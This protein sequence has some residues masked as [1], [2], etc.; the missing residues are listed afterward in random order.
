MAT[1]KLKVFANTANTVSTTAITNVAIKTTSSSEQAVIKNITYEATDPKYPVTAS[2]TNGNASLS[3]PKTTAKTVKNSDTLAGS[4]IVDVSSTVNLKFDT[5]ADITTVG[6]ADARYFDGQDRGMFRL[7]DTTTTDRVS[8]ATLTYADSIGDFQSGQAQSAQPIV[9]GTYRGSSAFGIILDA[10]NSPTSSPAVAAGDKVYFRC[11]SDKVNGYNA[12]G[13]LITWNSGGANNDSFDF[14]GGT[15]G[16]CTDGTYIYAIDTG[17]DPYLYRRTI[18]GNVASTI[19]MSQS[20]YG[21]STNQGGFTI[22]HDGYIYVHQNAGNS[23][24]DKI[25][26]TTGAVT[27]VGSCGVGSYSAGAILTQAVNGKFYIIEVGSGA[28]QNNI[29]D[30]STFTR[31]NVT[32]VSLGV[33]TEYGNLGLEIQPGVGL[34]FYN[35]TAVFIDVNSMTASTGSTESQSTFFSTMVNFASNQNASSFANIPLHQ[36]PGATV[37]RAVTHKVYADGVLIEGVA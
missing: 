6:Y 3:T 27:S 18:V 2:L 29:I 22:Y 7:F 35:S 23:N 16:A 34:F 10:N 31:S 9:T 20:I 37:A 32:M 33:S 30:L 14:G 4:Q 11:H 24:I 19:N 12:A 28:D 13:I 5:G 1:E 8:G 17:H 25:N 26:V 36:I 15:Y 21:Q